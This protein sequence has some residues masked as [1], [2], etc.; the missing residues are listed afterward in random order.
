LELPERFPPLGRGR[1]PFGKQ[2]RHLAYLLSLR[3]GASEPTFCVE[4]PSPPVRTMR[5]RSLRLIT[6]S[7][8]RSCPGNTANQ[9]GSA[10]TDSYSRALSRSTPV[11]VSSS[12]S[13]KKSYSPTSR[14]PSSSRIRS[15]TARKSRAPPSRGSSL[16]GQSRCSATLTCASPPSRSAPRR[17]PVPA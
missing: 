7:V 12:H 1:A 8:G 15:F 17:P 13:Q 14:S 10:R 6:S 4:S 5:K 9:F 16:A 3:F 2:L 11:Q